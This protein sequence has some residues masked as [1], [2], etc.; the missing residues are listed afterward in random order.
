MDWTLINQPF[1]A[2]SLPEA[3]VGIGGV[4]IGAVATLFSVRL[5]NSAAQRR[6]VAQVETAER[7]TRLSSL[8]PLLERYAEAHGQVFDLAQE[9]IETGEIELESYLAL[10][11]LLV[12]L[13]P[14]LRDDLIRVFTDLVAKRIGAAD[15]RIELKTLQDSIRDAV[16]L[17]FLDLFFGELLRKGDQV[18]RE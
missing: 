2:L 11:P 3:A 18:E 16:G 4:A 9:V 13:E 1:L 7:A 5:S 8:Q 10:R 17:P 12:Y 14:S 15:A 6:L